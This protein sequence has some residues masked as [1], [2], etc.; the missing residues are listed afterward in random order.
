M[1]NKQPVIAF[2]GGGNMT[3]GLISGLINSGINKE[4]LEVSDRN[5]VK[6]K[7]IAK[8]WGVRAHTS[9]LEAIRSADL[10]VLAVKPKDMHDLVIEIREVL[11]T[12]QPL[13]LSVAAGIHTNH[14]EQWLGFHTAIVRAVP[15]TPALLGVGATGL[16]ANTLVTEEQKNLSES[17]LRAVGI[18]AWVNHEHEMDSIAAL[19]SSGPAYFF[20]IMEALQQSAEALG[21]SNSVARLLTLQTAYGAARMALESNIDLEELKKQVA[22]PDGITESALHIL[23][24]GGIRALFNKTL[25]AAKFRSMEISHLFD[26]P[27]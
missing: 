15:N 8:K 22:S 18:T 24:E 20:L 23:E 2:I 9:N 10:I 16:Y 25:N 1:L 13:I 5:P 11:Q 14:L 26:I 3:Q 12:R 21:L 7:E 27:H 17:L 4:T 6:L 19:S